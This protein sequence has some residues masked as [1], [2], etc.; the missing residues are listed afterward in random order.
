MVQAHGSSLSGIFCRVIIVL[1]TISH[2]FAPAI[3]GTS[4]FE[5][6]SQAARQEAHAEAQE[7]CSSVLPSG[8]IK[9]FPCGKEPAHVCSMVT[10]GGDISYFVCGDKQ[11]GRKL[12]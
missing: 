9:Y 8:R 7:L 4:R 5:P 2:G 6:A 12:D 10:P 3:A 1:V 11:E